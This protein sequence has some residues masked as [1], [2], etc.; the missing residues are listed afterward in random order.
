MQTLM[1]MGLPLRQAQCAAWARSWQDGCKT[2]SGGNLPGSLHNAP[3]I[4]DGRAVRDLL[5]PLRGVQSTESPRGD[6]QPRPDHGRRVGTRVQ[7]F[8]AAVRRRRAEHGD[9][10][11]VLVRRG[12]PS[13]V[14]NG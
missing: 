5:Q 3:A 8:A 1:S 12:T 14:G 10:I 6:P 4:H 9:A 7:R 13:A 2:T 11:G